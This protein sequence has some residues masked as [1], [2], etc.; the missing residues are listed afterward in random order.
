MDF[1]QQLLR[2]LFSASDQL[3]QKLSERW[4]EHTNRR[5][6]IVLVL[7]GVVAALIHIYFIQPPPNFPINALISVP[8]GT[9]GEV[10]E[11]LYEQEVIRSPLAFRMLVVVLG[12]ERSVRAGDYLFKQP[13]DVV[14]VARAVSR[15]LFGL[16]PLR[17]RI[18]EGATSRE[19]AIIFRSQLERFNEQTFVARAR[20][21]EGYLFPDT[22]FFLPNTTE[23][24]VLESMRQNFDNRV[25]GL[26][27]EIDASGR[28]LDDIITMASI[29][30]REARIPADRRMIS[31]VLWNRI[32]RKMALQVD[33][34]FLYS[35]GK[36]TFQL[37]LTDLASDSPYNT[38][39][40][41]GLP[42]TPIGSPSMDSID[43]ALHPTKSNYLFYLA[44]N[45]GVTHFSKTYQEHL[46]K[47]RLYLG[48]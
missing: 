15:G 8:E 20:E 24:T 48:S 33:A 40:Y 12:H 3:Q 32:D 26:S 2:R 23:D 38:Y 21:Q 35:I 47:K 25:A 28:T 7:M 9:L 31:G 5:T 43:A 10:A 16:E 39:R 11:T 29:I 42:P 19:M 22:Y 27:E 34:V 45:S 14:S 30:E 13:R 46:R 4:R 44:D 1:V 6:T 36:S 17:I 18:P 41:K 37:T